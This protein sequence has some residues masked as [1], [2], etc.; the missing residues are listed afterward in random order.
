MKVEGKEEEFSSDLKAVH[1]ANLYIMREIDKLSKRHGISYRM[2]SGTLLGAVRHRG[3]IPWDD[4]VD[5]LFRREEALCRFFRATGGFK[6]P[7]PMGAPKGKS[8]L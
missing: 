2:D 6:A 7:S 5:L 1:E 8:L 4:D 3:F